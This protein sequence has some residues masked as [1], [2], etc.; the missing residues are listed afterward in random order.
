M[1]SNMT[2]LKKDGVSNYLYQKG[3]PEPIPTLEVNVN[4][5]QICIGTYNL[6]MQPP[7]LTTTSPAGAPASSN[8]VPGAPSPGAMTTTTTGNGAVVPP[9]TTT[10]APGAP[11]PSPTTTEPPEC[12]IKFSQTGRKC[13]D[14]DVL[15][16]S[17]DNSC[18]MLLDINLDTGSDHTI[19]I[20]A[21]GL[22]NVEV[23]F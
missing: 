15:T 16:V 1:V 4:E 13:R 5:N 6:T 8:S 22:G 21:N 7:T 10:A 11:A 2:D 18:E 14:Q 19:F 12:E 17:E 23:C 3:S 9:P 20:N